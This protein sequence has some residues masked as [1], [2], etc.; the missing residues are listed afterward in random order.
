MTK[1]TYYLQFTMSSLNLGQNR[2]YKFILEVHDCFNR[3]HIA[4]CMHVPFP[5][6]PHAH[7]KPMVHEKNKDQAE[8]QLQKSRKKVI[9]NSSYKYILEVRDCLLS[10][11]VVSRFSKS[12]RVTGRNK[13]KAQFERHV[14]KVQILFRSPHC[15]LES[16]TWFE[17]MSLHEFA[18]AEKVMIS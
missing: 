1:F 4:S 3:S 2:S 9:G 5:F 18:D 13:F 15:F 16:K 8:W 14:S 12:W 17:N 11:C 10:Y 6:I 7:H